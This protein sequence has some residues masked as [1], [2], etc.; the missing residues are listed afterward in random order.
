MVSIEP[1]VGHWI[2]NMG[3]GNIGVFL[4]LE[5]SPELKSIEVNLG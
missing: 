3:Q 5:N 2:R 4:K 1:G